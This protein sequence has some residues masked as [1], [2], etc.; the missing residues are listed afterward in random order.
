MRLAQGEACSCLGGRK[1]ST[2]I[3]SLWAQDGLKTHF[4]CIYISRLWLPP[5]SG[6]HGY[7]M[8]T[9]HRYA[10]CQNTYTYKIKV[11]KYLRKN[12]NKTKPKW[13][14]N[15]GGQDGS[16]GQALAAEF[17]NLTGFFPTSEGGTWLLQIVLWCDHW[18]LRHMGRAP[19]YLHTKEIITN[20]TYFP[21]HILR[22]KSLTLGSRTKIPSQIWTT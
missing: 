10:C 12:M 2:Y 7:C 22:P 21:S 3:S 9:V 18:V 5:S 14:Q 13:K 4:T 6:F 20:P 8:H 19:T 15:Q 11:N 17:H 16:I 1:V